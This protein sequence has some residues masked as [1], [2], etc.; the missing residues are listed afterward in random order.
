MELQII[1]R[2]I[3]N[4]WKSVSTTTESKNEFFIIE[5]KLENGAKIA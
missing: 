1:I 2:N 5:E 3:K 4:Q